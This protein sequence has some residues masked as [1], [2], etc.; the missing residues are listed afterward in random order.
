[1]TT[2]PVQ[3]QVAEV[4]AEA[5]NVPFVGPKQR[6][7]AQALADAGLLPTG[8]TEWAWVTPGDVRITDLRMEKALSAA[9]T[10][11]GTAQCRTVYTAPDPTPWRDA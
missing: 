10:R 4:I 9:A 11:S 5:Q 2:D 7:I 6:K 1:M 3:Q 8:R